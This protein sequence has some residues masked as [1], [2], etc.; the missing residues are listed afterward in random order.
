MNNEE[1]L[2]E[3]RKSLDK[4]TFTL[5][6]TLDYQQ[7]LKLENVSMKFE[8]Q[9]LLKEKRD[10]INQIKSATC[11]A[12]ELASKKVFLSKSLSQAKLN[13]KISK[14]QYLKLKEEIEA[15]ITCTTS[16]SHENHVLVELIDRV[17]S[18]ILEK[19]QEKADFKSQ[20]FE[21]EKELT[22]K[23]DLFRELSTSLQDT[24]RKLA[25]L[26]S[27]KNLRKK[28]LGD[29]DQKLIEI[30]VSLNLGCVELEKLQIDF[31]YVESERT[32]KNDQLSSI[33]NKRDTV[34]NEININKLEIANIQKELTELSGKIVCGSKD[35]EKLKELEMLTSLTLEHIQREGFE[36]KKRI[37]T[38]EEKIKI[39]K[40]D[41]E[42]LSLNLKEQKKLFEVLKNGEKISN[43]KYLQFTEMI[44][45]SRMLYLANRDLLDQIEKEDSIPPDL[46]RDC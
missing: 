9:M 26:T 36:L 22:R 5:D 42:S 37:D 33:E 19:R 2:L 32:K 43:L 7:R 31:N 35:F 34:I 30:E 10:V 20:V 17:S 44:E 1:V 18:D 16:F 39:K 13:L 15:L 3:R 46:P 23:Q 6:E 40:K 25:E 45:R 41:L 27:G 14:D 8:L 29:I 12:S 38:T 11:F 21:L 28:E 24:S 4:K